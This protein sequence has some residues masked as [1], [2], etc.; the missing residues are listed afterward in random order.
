[1]FIIYGHGIVDPAAPIALPTTQDGFTVLKEA[2][3]ER[4]FSPAFSSY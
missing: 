2:S 3:L 4:G 1:M